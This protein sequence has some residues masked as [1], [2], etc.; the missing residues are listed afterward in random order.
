MD[1]VA[2]DL[3]QTRARRLKNQV[4]DRVPSVQGICQQSHPSLIK[5]DI[6]IEI[7]IDT[8]CKAFRGR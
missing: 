2:G 6:S 1:V 3:V 5:I 8:V 4:L 7:D